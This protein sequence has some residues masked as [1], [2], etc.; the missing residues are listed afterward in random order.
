LGVFLSLSGIAR[1]NVAELLREW[2]PTVIQSLRPC[3]SSHDIPSGKRWFDQI[4][5]ATNTQS[6]GLF[7][8]T[9]EN[10]DSKWM[11]FEEGA[12]SNTQAES[13]IAGLLLQGLSPLKISGQLSQFQHV[14]LNK[15]GMNKWAECGK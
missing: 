6:Y 7:C 5:N 10:I 2:L 12:L 8:L 15:V 4:S 3:I 14:E 13:H 11:H 9:Q 1:K